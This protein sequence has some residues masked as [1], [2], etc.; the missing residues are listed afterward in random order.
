M[1]TQAADLNGFQLW[2]VDEGAVLKP[3]C[4][5]MSC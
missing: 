3:L 2:W 1:D 4:L 5:M